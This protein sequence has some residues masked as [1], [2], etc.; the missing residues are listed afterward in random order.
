[1]YST[2]SAIYCWDIPYSQ[3]YCH[4]KLKLIHANRSIFRFRFF[5]YWRLYWRIFGKDWSLK[6]GG[7]TKC[8]NSRERVVFGSYNI[9]RTAY[10]YVVLKLSFHFDHRSVPLFA[11]IELT[12]LLTVFFQTTL[13]TCFADVPIKGHILVVISMLSMLITIPEF[14]A[15]ATPLSSALSNASIYF[16]LH[17]ASK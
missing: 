16:T 14:V 9:L 12:V 13:V 10:H 2:R 4:C 1:M 17:R 6:K 15:L 3:W 11:P 7:P 8:S 5:G